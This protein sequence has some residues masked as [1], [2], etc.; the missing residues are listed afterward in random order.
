MKTRFVAGG[1]LLTAVLA[2]VVA[3]SPPPDGQKVFLESGCTRCHDLD[4]SGGFQGPRLEGLIT[5]WTAESLDRFLADPPAF[6]K[7]NARLQAY[8]DDYVTPMPKLVIEPAKRKALVEYLLKTH[9]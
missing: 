4:G 1:G 6:V 2:L 9:P 5:K 8:Q 7:E 3:C